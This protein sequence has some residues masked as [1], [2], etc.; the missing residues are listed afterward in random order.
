MTV[1]YLLNAGST[2][3]ATSFTVAGN[4]VMAA[5]DVLVVNLWTATAVT[6]VTD[7]QGNS[8]IPVNLKGAA[9]QWVT[10]GKTVALAA[11]DTITIKLTS[12][13]A[14]NAV[15]IGVPG[16]I[17]APVDA[18]NSASATSTSASVGTGTLITSDG[19]TAVAM[20]ASAASLPTWT[21][22]FTGLGTSHG[23]STEFLGGAYQQNVGSAGATASAT[24]TSGAWIALV[25]TLQ[26]TSFVNA[27]PNPPKQLA[28]Q[29]AMSSDMNALAQTALFMRRPPMV[30]A[31]SN[32]SGTGQ[33]MTV[34]TSA[35]TY[36]TVQRDT[37]G[38]FA[39]SLPTRLTVQTPGFYSVRYSIPFAAAGVN[40]QIW[41]R[42]Q[43]GANNPAGAG[44][45]TPY[46]YAFAASGNGNDGCVCGGGLIPVYMY[47][48][49]FIQVMASMNTAANM[50]VSPQ[51][52]I[53]SMRMAS[54]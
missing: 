31:Q 53:V 42:L 30:I 47:Q 25:V 21:G 5:G 3:G 45:Q 8:Y 36:S 15:V 2:A 46:W 43:T 24:V 26:M 28:G 14:G 12:S 17:Y 7:S 1:P 50:P 23:S 22:S 13:G 11:I 16:A 19:Q 51:P 32:T 39:P 52:A 4:A 48:A 9:S 49:D 29:I 27:A 20:V 40:C 34:A 33:S 38:F 35:I 6:S 41:A 18:I 54:V 10:A 44:V 37:D